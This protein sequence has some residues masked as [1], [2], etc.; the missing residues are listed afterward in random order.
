MKFYFKLPVQALFAVGYKFQ[1]LGLKNYHLMEE[2]I[3]AQDDI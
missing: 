1:L 2:D 3:P